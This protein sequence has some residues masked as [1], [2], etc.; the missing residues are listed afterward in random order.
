MMKRVHV[1]F[2]GR[3]Q[4]VGF[5]YTAVS[6]ARGFLVTGFV[7]NLDDGRVELLAEGEEED[8]KSFLA[9]I[10]AEMAG[11]TTRTEESWGEARG[12]VRGFRIVY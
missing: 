11:H 7:R 8:L 9:K 1:F 5:R 12:D 4:G 6:I 3:V 2:S 10:S